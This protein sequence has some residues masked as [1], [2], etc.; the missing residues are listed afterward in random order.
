MESILRV[1]KCTANL[2]NP[3]HG[4]KSIAP[5]VV[6]FALHSADGS[7]KSWNLKSPRGQRVSRTDCFLKADVDCLRCI[8]CGEEK[9]QFESTKLAFDDFFQ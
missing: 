6:R 3:L 2:C 7:D 9:S 5:R 8:I 4:M 1:D